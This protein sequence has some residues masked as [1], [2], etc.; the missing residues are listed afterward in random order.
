MTLAPQKP[1]GGR[2]SEKG[3]EAV[4][5]IAGTAGEGRSEI[6]MFLMKNLEE[7]TE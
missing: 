1:R 7:Q 5:S 4:L 6:L 2:V 3:C